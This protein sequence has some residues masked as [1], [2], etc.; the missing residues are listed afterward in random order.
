[1]TRRGKIARLPHSI[2]E[3]I[4]QRLENGQ[5][6]KQIAQW[7][8]NL[9][10]VASLMAAEF[11][12]QP[13]SEMN[14]SN[15]KLGGFRDWEAQQAALDSALLFHSEAAQLS[16]TGGPQL[17]DQLALCLTAALRHTSAQADDP[18]Q[19]LEELRRLRRSAIPKNCV[20]LARFFLLFVSFVCFCKILLVAALPRQAFAPLRLC[21]KNPRA[22][23]GK[24]LAKM[25]DSYTLQGR[26]KNAKIRA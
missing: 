12:G 7:L 8:N 21:V 11:D 22:I 16:Q 18:A 25:N 24:I 4:N 1:M 23:L 3:Q 9:P 2:R 15:W 10:E 20:F 17:A 6:A 14:L 13:V 5:E 26:A 19:E